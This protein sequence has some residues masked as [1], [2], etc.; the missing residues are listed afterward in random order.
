MYSVASERSEFAGF[1]AKLKFQI[2]QGCST[3]LALPA[4]TSWCAVKN[5]WLHLTCWPL[6]L[7]LCLPSA[8]WETYNYDS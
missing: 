4:G 7:E 1:S 2:S 5:R 8:Y 3:A 6:S